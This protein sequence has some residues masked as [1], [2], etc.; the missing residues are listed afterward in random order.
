MIDDQ[1][2]PQATEDGSLT[3]YSEEFG[4]A[5]HSSFGAKQE[6][7]VRYIEPCEIKQLAANQSTIRL[8]DICYGLGYNSAAA[9]EAI[10]SVNPHCKVEL[11]ALEISA[12]VPRQAISHNLLAQWQ[13]PVSQLL[14]QLGNQSLVRE[15]LLTA[16]LILGDARTTIRAVLDSSMAS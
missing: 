14:S 16:E 11:I 4:E 9:L 3:F 7:E 6:A 15:K 10:W 12:D 5:F 2:T 1:F 13:P 8:L